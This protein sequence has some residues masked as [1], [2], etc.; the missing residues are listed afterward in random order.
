M[1]TLLQHG[2]HTNGWHRTT[3]R[4]RLVC[5]AR[6]PMDLCRDA[7]WWNDS[8][9]AEKSSSSQRKVDKSSRSVA[10]PSQPPGVRRQETVA[11]IDNLARGK[12][13]V[14]GGPVQWR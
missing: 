6:P 10:Q 8:R 12:L 3:R 11:F 5:L 1:L 13:V 4:L 14:V 2:S 9:K 7:T